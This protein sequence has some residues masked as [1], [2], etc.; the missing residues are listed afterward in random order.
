VCEDSRV[1][2]EQSLVGAMGCAS[3]RSHYRLREYAALAQAGPDPVAQV[4]RVDR[5]SLAIETAAVLDLNEVGVTDTVVAAIWRFGPSAAAYAISSSAEHE[6]LGADIAIAHLSTS[7]ILLYQ[8]KLAEHKDG[9]F[10]LKSPVTK[11]QVRQLSQRRPITIQG[12]P[13][14]VTGRLALYQQ[15]LTPYLSHL[16]SRTCLAYGGSDQDRS[17]QVAAV[18]GDTRRRSAN[19]TTRTYSPGRAALRAACW[20]HSYP[21]GLNGLPRSPWPARGP[22]NSTPTNGSNRLRPTRASAGLPRNS[23]RTSQQTRNSDQA[24]EQRESRVS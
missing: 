2:A 20:L 3:W 13:Y 4:I 6:H 24:T 11:T 23:R 16:P 1:T 19:G 7:R 22:G 12:I 8:A 18:H 14:E 9:K 15:D 5:G 21:A 10:R 17:P